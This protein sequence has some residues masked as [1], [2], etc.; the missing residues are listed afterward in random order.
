MKASML[1]FVLTNN[2]KMMKLM[3]S[4]GCSDHEML[5][6]RIFRA[7]R[8]VSSNLAALDF[9]RADT[10]LFRNLL[11]GTLWDEVLEREEAQEK[12]LTFKDYLL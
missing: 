12:W 11:G 5:Q 10:G 9:E 6:I 1:D 4:L 7:T 8:T 2:L 3:G